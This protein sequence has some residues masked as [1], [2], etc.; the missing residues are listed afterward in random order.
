MTTIYTTAL[1]FVILWIVCGVYAYFMTLRVFHS[2]YPRR[3]AADVV[4]DRRVAIITGLAGWI[5]LGVALS[6]RNIKGDL[7]K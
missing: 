1:F 5:G 7:R 6:F 3:T 4:K 2:L